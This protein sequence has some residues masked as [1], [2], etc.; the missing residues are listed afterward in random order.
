MKSPL[1][2]ILGTI[3]GTIMAFLVIYWALYGMGKV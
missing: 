1:E 2:F 3:T